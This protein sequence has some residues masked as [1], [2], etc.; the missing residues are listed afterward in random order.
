MTYSFEIYLSFIS[1]VLFNFNYTYLY[2]LQDPSGAQV[3]RTTP[4]AACYYTDVHPVYF[5]CIEHLYLKMQSLVHSMC[6]CALLH[7]I[8]PRIVNIGSFSLK[9]TQ[10]V[11]GRRDKKYKKKDSISSPSATEA[12]DGYTLLKIVLIVAQVNL[13]YICTL[14]HL[15]RMNWSSLHVCVYTIHLCNVLC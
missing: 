10:I 4:L 14:W 5:Q 6:N 15:E 13:F 1:G 7:Y 2:T 11:Y 9:I 12:C 8:H 3:Y